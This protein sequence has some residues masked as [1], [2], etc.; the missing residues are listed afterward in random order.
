MEIIVIIEIISVCLF[1]LFLFVLSDLMFGLESLC[2]QGCIQSQ[3]KQ[4]V[5]LTV[6]Q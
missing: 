2:A 6:E 1:I 3:Q 4:Y 5:P